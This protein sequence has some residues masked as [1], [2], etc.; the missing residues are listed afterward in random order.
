MTLVGLIK[1]DFWSIYRLPRNVSTSGNLSA[2]TKVAQWYV[3]DLF[4]TVWH[5]GEFETINAL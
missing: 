5:D 4:L 3:V 2:A 1:S